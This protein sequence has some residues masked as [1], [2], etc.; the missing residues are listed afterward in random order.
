V[1]EERFS[2]DLEAR[3]PLLDV[4]KDAA[5]VTGTASPVGQHENEFSGKRMQRVVKDTI[6]L[7]GAV[8]LLAV[9]SPLLLLIAL[10]VKL[11]DGGPVFYR[12]RVVGRKGEFGAYKFRTMRPDADAVLAADAALRAQFEQDF[13]LRKDPRVTQVGAVLRKYSLDELP[14]LLNVLRGEMSLV[15]PRM[16][17]APELEKYGPFRGRL[18]TV[19]PGLTGYWQVNGRQRVSYEERVKMDIY[20]LDHWSLAMDI[21]IILKTPVK[22][23]RGEGAY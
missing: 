12:R 6:D 1:N 9:L 17:T 3:M 22:V 16:I 20:Y 4:D 14:Q 10:C 15:G 7:A 8:V 13:K 11:D 18:L 5:T 19:K 2:G 21:E 23:V